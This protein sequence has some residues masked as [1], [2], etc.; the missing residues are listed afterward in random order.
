MSTFRQLYNRLMGDVSGLDLF[1]AKDCI[2]YAWRDIREA[3]RWSFLSAEAS[4]DI[5]AQVTTGTAAV[6]QFSDLV[7]PDAAAK[8][9]WDVL[10]MNIPLT[11][12]QFR[13]GDGP[14]YQIIAYDDSGAGSM[15]LERSYKEDTDAT[16]A[17]SIYRAYFTMPAD[18]LTFTDVK[19]I[20]NGRSL[21]TD[22]SR[23]DLDDM[24]DPQRQSYGDP[25]YIAACGADSSGEPVFELWPH[26][27][28]AK[29]LVVRYERAGADFASDAESLPAIIP[30]SLLMAKALV[31][32]CQWAAM[33]KPKDA[34]WGQLAVGHD[35]LFRDQLQK[36]KI[37]D[38][39]TW[40]IAITYAPEYTQ[41]SGGDARWR[42]SHTDG[43][44]Y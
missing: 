43:I 19:D 36:V 37:L 7:V 35:A 20:Q 1:K 23:Q 42:Q 28:T 2:N 17:Y 26:L 33:N 41:R 9:V 5:P 40:P 4:I 21:N 18:F 44:S 27:L 29:S 32:A 10:G 6:T 24:R 34:P 38:E 13:I 15:Q 12:R 8:A 11:S 14:L 22:L 16:A 30:E 25:Y 3:R 39:E 31:Y